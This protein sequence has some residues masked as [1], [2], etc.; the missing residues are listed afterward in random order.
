MCRYTAK[1]QTSSHPSC[2]TRT[3]ST[4]LADP[5]LVSLRIDSM[6]RSLATGLPS[7][8][9]GVCSV[10]TLDY[11]LYHSTSTLSHLL[12]SSLPHR[13]HSGCKFPLHRYSNSRENQRYQIF[14]RLCR[15]F[16]N[17]I[18]ISSFADMNNGAPPSQG[19]ILQGRPYVDTGE[20]VA[21]R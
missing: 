15:K 16:S 14:K 3:P 2:L 5:T 19:T 18:R 12:S 1:Q 4:Q 6:E 21:V 9:A 10:Q 17:L 13:R 8:L 20:L 7:N 11:T